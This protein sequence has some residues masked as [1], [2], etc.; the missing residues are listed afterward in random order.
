[1]DFIILAV[2]DNVYSESEA[3]KMATSL[4]H[5]ITL[6]NKHK[7]KNTKIKAEKVFFDVD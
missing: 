6:T 2:L 3:S 5:H 4:G 1:M 7:L